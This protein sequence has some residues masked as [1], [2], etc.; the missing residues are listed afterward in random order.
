ML[1]LGC[2]LHL[3]T[4]WRRMA[5]A[6]LWTASL[7]L[8]AFVFLPLDVWLAAPIERHAPPSN[9]P[10]RIDGILVLGGNP[11]RTQAG[12]ALA[13][14]YPNAV[15]LF[16]GGAGG[17]SGINHAR[18]AGALYRGLG[19]APSRLLLEDRSVNTLDS[20]VRAQA[21]AQRVPGKTWLLVTSA[22]HM[23]RAH[24]VARKIGWNVVPYSSD[25]ISRFNGKA[26]PPSFNAAQKM[27]SAGSALHEYIGLWLYRREGSL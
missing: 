11:A 24:G 9:L 4:A 8:L 14:R 18:E 7:I 5:M 20:L 6:L 10:A 17:P 22:I 2:L 15:L 19:L 23:P 3:V 1:V 16:S 12:A 13:Q 25:Y 27:I 21:M 26:P